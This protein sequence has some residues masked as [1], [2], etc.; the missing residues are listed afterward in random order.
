MRRVIIA[1]IV[2]AVAAAAGTA[3]AGK[4]PLSGNSQAKPSAISA[5]CHCQRGPRGPRGLRGPQGP[6]GIRA[7]PDRRGR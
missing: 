1:G 7:Q 6:A 4:S 5:A 2:V 3:M